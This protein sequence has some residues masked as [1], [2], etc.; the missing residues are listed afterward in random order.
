MTVMDAPP[1][2]RN[3]Y[4]PVVVDQRTRIARRARAIE[5]E[6]RDRLRAMGRAVTIDVDCYIG[7]VAGCAVKLELLKGQASRGVFVDS[8]ELTRLANVVARGLGALGLRSDALE[9]PAPP[10]PRPT[11]GETLRQI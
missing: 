3:P 9:K 4:R 11:L 2:R 1:K 6:L 7:S 10:P 8:E 5:S